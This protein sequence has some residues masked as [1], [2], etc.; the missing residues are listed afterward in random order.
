MGYE[1]HMRLLQ[2][3]QSAV[4]IVVPVLLSL[5]MVHNVYI[6]NNMWKARIR[7]S[8]CRSFSLIYGWEQK[9]A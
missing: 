3:L 4:K 2:R 5:D 7:V 8:L 9:S 1:E 6:V